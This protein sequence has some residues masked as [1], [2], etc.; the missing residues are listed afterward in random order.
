MWIV[1]ST[2]TLQSCIVY[3]TC[4]VFNDEYLSIW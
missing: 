2:C 4:M 3:E 1:V